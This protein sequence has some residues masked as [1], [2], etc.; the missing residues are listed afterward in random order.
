MSDSV[1]NK[2]QRWRHRID[3]C[4]AEANSHHTPEGREALQSIMDSYERLIDLVQRKA[5]KQK[6]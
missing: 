1:D 5:Q 4:R 3:E 2:I 6:V